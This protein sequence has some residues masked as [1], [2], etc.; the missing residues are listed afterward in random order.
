MEPRIVTKSAFLVVGVPFRGL[1]S[2]APYENGGGNNEIGAAW[3]EFNRRFAEI[4]NASGPAIG[5]CFGMPN[6]NEPWY[7][8]GVEVSRAEDVPPGMMSMSVPEQKY[9]VFTCTLPTL[10]ET[11]GRIMEEW[12]PQSGCEHADAPDFEL[13]DEK[14]NPN[15]P[16]HGEIYVYWP[17]K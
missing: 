1:L 9:A 10:H 13:Y 7:I 12:Q 8:A 16:T 4:R 15:D 5:L 3:D 11:Y 14:F 6:P 17:I 2:S